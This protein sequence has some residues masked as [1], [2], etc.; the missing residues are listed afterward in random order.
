MQAGR[1]A[2]PQLGLVD[3]QPGAAHDDPLLG[4]GSALVGRHVTWASLTVADLPVTD[5][6][7]NAGLVPPGRE[8][9]TNLAGWLSRYAPSRR[10]STAASTPRQPS[11]SFLQTPA[12]GEVKSEWKAESVGWFDEADPRRRRRSAPASCSTASCRG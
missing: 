11:V 5:V 2:L 6:G 10:R 1:Q 8:R 7:V 12:W 3:L 9:P 4:P